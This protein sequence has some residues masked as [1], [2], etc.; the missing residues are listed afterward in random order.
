MRFSTPAN[1]VESPCS[2]SPLITSMLPTTFRGQVASTSRALA[3]AKRPTRRGQQREGGG[4]AR[5]RGPP[6]GAGARGG[7]GER[8][9]AGGGARGRGGGGRRGRGGRGGGRGGRGGGAVGAGGG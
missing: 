9:A 1:R 3:D 2:P 6:A 5:V 4:L 7:G 8:G